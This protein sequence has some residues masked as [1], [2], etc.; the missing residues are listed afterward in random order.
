MGGEG[1]RVAVEDLAQRGVVGG[2]EAFTIDDFFGDAGDRAEISGL[3]HEAL[4]VVV[5]VGIE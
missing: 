1:F 5:A 3:V 4:E 2:G